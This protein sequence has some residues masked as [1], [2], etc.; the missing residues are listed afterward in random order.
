MDHFR[1][2]KDYNDYWE[3]LTNQD[4]ELHG[5]EDLATLIHQAK[6]G[7]EQYQP[8]KRT[9]QIDHLFQHVMGRLKQESQK[10]A[11]ELSKRLVAL[12]KLEKGL[13]GFLVARIEA[14]D[15]RIHKLQL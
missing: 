3:K 13:A 2:N 4:L 1:A 7:E 14:M 11:G 10:D 8:E 5:L 6:M 9:G 15:H 12:E